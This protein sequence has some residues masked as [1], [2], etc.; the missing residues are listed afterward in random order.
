MLDD[1]SFSVTPTTCLGVIG[2]NGVGKS[3]LLHILAGLVV[4]TAGEIRVEPPGATV[5]YLNQE[6]TARATRRSGHLSPGAP[7]WRASR[8]S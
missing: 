2:P 3:T 6:H 5:G 1:V 7:G 4:P 8:R